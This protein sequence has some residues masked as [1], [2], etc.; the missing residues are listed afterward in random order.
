M[1]VSYNEL[2]DRALSDLKGNWGNAIGATLVVGGIGIAC[3]FVPFIGALGSWIITGP[4]TLGMAIFMLNF[5]RGKKPEVSEVFE[6]F[7][8][9]GNALGTYIL[10]GLI[11]FGFTL[12]L[13]IP[14][15]IRG[16]A[17]SQVFFI[18]AKEP[19]LG[20]LDALKKSR[21]MMDGHK[22]D[23][24]LLSLSF[25]GWFLLSILTLYIG[26][27]WLIP[28]MRVTLA[29]FHR[30]ISKDEVEDTGNLSTELD[31]LDDAI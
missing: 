7:Q 18:L 28:Y 5:A 23:F 13:I 30:E 2:K 1:N 27:I 10:M 17:Y 15:I 4:L 14:G 24:F 9:F 29:H 11:V 16:I 8:N 21:E 25:I 6:G 12:L 22:M 26:L 31:I 3:Q 20:P 19:E